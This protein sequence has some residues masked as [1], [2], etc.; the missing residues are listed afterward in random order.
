MLVDAANDAYCGLALYSHFVE[1]AKTNKVTLK[2]DRY[3]LNVQRP[4]AYPGAPPVA[5]TFPPRA[6][7][8]QPR[9]PGVG[10]FTS[11]TRNAAASTSASA[12][13]ADAMEVDAQTEVKATA[14]ATEGKTYIRPS[15]LRAYNMWRESNMGLDGLCGAL[16][17]PINPLKRV[18]V[19]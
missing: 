12:S 8:P 19:M 16:R 13:R 6:A 4:Q 1:L 9:L 10:L 14:T 5:P 7:A 18:T 2:P 3:T 17:T 15:H 11:R